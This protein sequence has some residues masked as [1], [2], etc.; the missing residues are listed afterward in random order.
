MTL[1]ASIVDG[2]EARERRVEEETERERA[3]REARRRLD[4]ETRWPLTPEIVSLEEWLGRPEPVVS[5][6]IENWQPADTRVILTAAFKSGKTTARD[7]LLRS[8]ADGDPWLGRY[9]VHP[10]T[11][12]IAVLDTEMSRV[13]MRRW[14]RDQQIEHGDRVFVAP[15]RGQSAAFDVLD[16]DVRATWAGWLRDRGIAYLILDCLRPVLDALGLDESHDAGR[17]LVGFDA[18]LAEAGIPEGLIIHHH[19]HSGERSRGDSRLRDWPDVEWRIVRQDDDPASSRYIAAYGRDVDVPESELL[20]DVNNRRLRITD[21]SRQDR[22]VRAAL[23]AIL[24][25]LGKADE[26]QTG[27]QVKHALADSDHARNAIDA[28]LRLGV[29]QGD[30]TVEDGP[31][32]SRL[33]RVSRSVPQCTKDTASECP[34][35]Y[36]GRDTRTLSSQ[37]STA[38]SQRDTQPQE[39]EGAALESSGVPAGREN[40]PTDPPHDREPGEH[41]D[42]VAPVK[43]PAP[44]DADDP[45]RETFEL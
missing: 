19:G 23:E 24:E 21:G 42:T 22:A 26:P 6:R 16:P 28:A 14:L 2:I 9:T 30:L 10:P 43:W 15:L 33:Y 8:L 25:V 20:Y 37:P 5:W 3:R 38:V 39:G 11:G 35:P 7:N 36:R 27:R 31:R 40:A 44:A 45:A 18:L 4:A 13:Q 34:A 17:F 41:D 32:R 1:T 12:T 29:R